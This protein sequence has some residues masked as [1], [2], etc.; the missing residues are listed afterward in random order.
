VLALLET[1][2][3]GVSGFGLLA[4]LPPTYYLGLA[5]LTVGFAVSA[6]RPRAQP[7]VLGAY[8]V[9]LVVV[10]HATTAVLYPEP[11]YTWTYKHIG[12]IDY[13]LAHGSVDR[14]IDIYHNWPG[15]FALNAWLSKAAGVS[16]LEYAGGAQLFFGLV[17][18]A[19]VV[20]A[21]R[22]VTRDPRLR[23]SAAW[24]FV[25][26]NWTGQDYLAPQAFA[27]VLSVV[28][29]G[30]AIRCA[31]WGAPPRTRLGWAAL[32]AAN[33]TATALLRGRG[34]R[35][36]PPTTPPLGARGALAVCAVCSLA[37]IISHQLT[38]IVLVLSLAVLALAM[39]RP[40]VY[41]IVGLAAVQAWWVW[42]SYDFVSRHFKLLEFDPSVSART[43]TGSVP[44]VALGADLSRAAIVLVLA[45]AV[46]G[47]LRRA[48]LGHWHGATLVLA[49]APALVLLVQSYGGEG[50]LRVFLFALPWL[51][52]FGAV[53]CRPPGTASTP[54]GRSWR[55][56][57]ASALVGTGALFG[58]F[59]QEPINYVTTSDVAVSRWYLDHAPEG[60]SLTYFAPNFPE[61]LNARYAKHLD[62]PR[63]LLQKPGF[64][65]ELRAQAGIRS[66]PCG[67]G[68]NAALALSAKSFVLKDSAP[69]HYL[70]LSPSQQRYARYHGLAS[71]E[72]Y[73]GLTRALRASSDFTVVYRSGDAVVFELAKQRA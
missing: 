65:Q 71:P 58:Y 61:R 34:P 51:C 39:R 62:E 19:A 37:I 59:G 12:V 10:L 27:F 35:A 25:L 17:G 45:L 18:V 4:A 47:L 67:R 48:R 8:V 46:A 36:R 57:A 6:S 53:A 44:G 70:I 42:L 14:S 40:P 20:F 31:P 24:L 52:F 38:P 1:D 11:R 54:L 63:D 60:S 55:L 50:P 41:L 43:V 15:F 33:R 49:T 5:V 3:T 68:C 26:A 7:A 69:R 32:R 23:W 22:G 9:A 73:T 30:L 28:V 72:A 66:S 13:V 2:P 29:L 16:P 56:I 21:L 64:V